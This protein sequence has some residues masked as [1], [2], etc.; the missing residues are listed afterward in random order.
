VAAA[1]DVETGALKAVGIVVVE[2]VG[3]VPMAVAV[4][5]PHLS[6][7]LEFPE[8]YAHFFGQRV[9]AIAHSIAR[10]STK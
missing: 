7:E 5:A 10:T 3:E 8:E 1:A 9:F 6:T 2:V 4:V